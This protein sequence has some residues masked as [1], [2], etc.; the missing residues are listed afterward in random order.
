MPID[1]STADVCDG[2]LALYEY[3]G[4]RLAL[5]KAKA[6]LNALT[7]AQN[8]V[9]GQIPTSLQYN[10]GYTPRPEDFWLNCSW[11]SAKVLLRMEKAVSG[12]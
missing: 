4:D 3:D 12:N 10:G 7:R 1:A 6:L 11:W 8:P 9:T 2:Y 5:A